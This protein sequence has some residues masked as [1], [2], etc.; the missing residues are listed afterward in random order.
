MSEENN[1]NAFDRL[2]AGLSN[3]DRLEMLSRIRTEQT[4]PVTLDAAPRDDD[5]KGGTLKLRIN[6]ESGFYRFMLWL[7]S[8][9]QKTTADKLYNEDMIS[10]IARKI[11]KNHPGLINHKNMTLDSI[12]CEQLRNLKEAADFF[13][14]YYIVANEAPGEFYVFMGSF[15]APELSSEINSKADP[16]LLP[17]SKEP[18]A[19]ART[20]FLKKLDEILKNMPADMKSRLYGAVSASNWLDQFSRLPLP[21]LLAQFT[22]TLPG[23]FSCPYSHARLDFNKL[24]SVFDSMIQIPREVLEALFIFSQRRDLSGSVS[25]E[26]VEKAMKELLLRADSYFSSI[27]I[28]L[29]GVPVVQVGQILNSNFDWQPASLTGA[30]AWFPVFR[31]QWRRIIEIR[32]N[33]WQ[34]ERKKLTLSS[35]LKADFGLN[36]F[37][38]MPYQPWTKMWSSVSFSFQLTGGFLSWFA[39]SKYSSV[40][41]PLNKLL[42]EG[43]FVNNDNRAEF[44]D[45]MNCIANASA[46]MTALNERLSPDGDLGEIFDQLASTKT[47]IYQVQGQIDSMMNDINAEIINSRLNFCKGV[48]SVEAVLAGAFD[49]VHDG[50]HDGIQNLSTIDGRRNAEFRESLMDSRQVLKRCLYY[51]SEIEPIDFASERK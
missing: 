13:R 49:D 5:G 1:R 24:A 12:F 45:G 6:N 34:R 28:F 3:E 8:F 21:H 16:F 4:E 26:D 23:E 38:V 39:A 50:T 32:W 37:P 43:I 29:N 18:P 31:T 35:G 40:A 27:R 10:S 33:D 11:S 30:E 47:G 44:S 15:V 48:R 2:V 22:E 46:R 19:D 36:D 9:F 14:P 25:D 42:M 17:L 7:R 41:D 20:D 51:I